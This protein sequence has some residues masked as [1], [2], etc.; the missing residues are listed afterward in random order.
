MDDRN[1]TL[2]AAREKKA[3]LEA[4]KLYL[5]REAFIAQ[6]QIQKDLAENWRSLLKNSNSFEKQAELFD[7][8]SQLVNQ[9]STANKT[10]EEG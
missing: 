2:L 4:N 7:K 1:R 8:I 10:T 5:Y 6:K 3:A 9:L